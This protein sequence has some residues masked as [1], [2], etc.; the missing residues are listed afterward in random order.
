MSLLPEA[1]YTA[2]QSRRL[3]ALAMERGGLAGAELMERAGAAAFARLQRR[4]PGARR[5]L[6]LCGPGNNGGDGYVLARLAREAGMA[7]TLARPGDAPA[8]GDAADARRRWLGA[9]GAETTGLPVL[10]GR[11]DVVVDALFGTG[12]ARP[13]EG[14]WAEAVAAVNA[15]AAPVLAV[16]LPSGLHADTGAVL[17]SAVRAD[18]TVTFMGLKRGMFTADG[19]DCCGRC[20]FDGLG[21]P[22]SVVAAVAP[23]ARRIPHDLAS[24]LLA[25]RRRNSH[26]GDFG[27]LL[28]VGGQPGMAG[29]VRLAAAA[30]GRS[31]A[32]LVQIATAAVHAPVLDATL[33]EAMVSGVERGTDL[34]PCLAAADVVLVGPGLGRGQWSQ[35]LFEAVLESGRPLVV[36]ADALFHLARSGHG[37]REDWILTPHPGEAGRLLG[38]DAAAVQRDRFAAVEALQRR[39]GGVTVLKGCGTLVRGPS[40][41]VSVCDLGNPGLASGGTGDVLAGVVAA[42]MAQGLSPEDSGRLGVLAHAGAGDAAAREGERGLVAGDLPDRLRAWLNPAPPAP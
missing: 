11:V 40:G 26:K 24:R 5:L 13:L 27:R 1:L 4:W 23:A 39:F 32:G 16:D 34:E 41:G 10:D 14:I 37:P 8:G 28:V 15:G 33:A 12:L 17:G 22:G 25:P 29:A 2:A 42:L 7:V 20:E 18:V 31:G 35:A 6:V 9:G 30:A 38:T 21:V 3:D 19:P 36:D